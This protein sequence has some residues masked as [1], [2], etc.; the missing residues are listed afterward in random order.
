MIIEQA[1]LTQMAAP[2]RMDDRSNDKETWYRIWLEPKE[3]IEVQVSNIPDGQSFALHL[4]CEHETEPEQSVCSS[5]TPGL[6]TYIAASAGYCYIKISTDGMFEEPEPYRLHVEK[7][8]SLSGFIEGTRHLSAQAG[9]YMLGPEPLVLAPGA[10]LEVEQGVVLNFRHG[11]SLHVHQGGTLNL[12]GRREA[13]ILIMGVKG[14]SAQHAWQELVID[15]R[16]CVNHQFV[17]VH[18]DSYSALPDYA[19]LS[20]ALADIEEPTTIPPSARPA[21]IKQWYLE[22]SPYI[23]AV[24]D[25]FTGNP[26][27]PLEMTELYLGI[28]VEIFTQWEV[29]SGRL[30]DARFSQGQVNYWEYVNGNFTADLMEAARL[31]AANQSSEEY[32][33]Q[34]LVDYL[35]KGK[36]WREQNGYFRLQEFIN[37]FDEKSFSSFYAIFLEMSYQFWLSHNTSVVYWDKKAREL[38]IYSQED[39]VERAFIDGVIIRVDFTAELPIVIPGY[40]NNVPPVGLI[41]LFL[42]HGPFRYPAHYPAPAPHDDLD[43]GNKT[44]AAMFSYYIELLVDGKTSAVYTWWLPTPAD[45]DL[46]EQLQAHGIRLDSSLEEWEREIVQPAALS[47][48]E[49]QRKYLKPVSNLHAQVSPYRFTANPIQFIFHWLKMLWKLTVAFCRKLFKRTKQKPVTYD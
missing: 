45:S 4:F 39:K 9:P 31:S 7:Y 6:G 18:Y 41:G 40:E 23:V 42:K 2:Q 1:A 29:E 33:I 37:P 20:S 32:R 24:V 22:A 38:G 8:A 21:L 3:A 26:L 44:T 19:P 36:A 47:V 28:D 17:V 43:Y 11:Q 16:A 48:E 46:K 10:V 35:N 49:I 5:N 13:P 12:N 34:R 15:E 25:G 14:G 30:S 27:H